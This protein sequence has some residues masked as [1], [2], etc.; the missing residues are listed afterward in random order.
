MFVDGWSHRMGCHLQAV[1]E[2]MVLEAGM[3]GVYWCQFAV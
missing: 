2:K 1:K 3:V